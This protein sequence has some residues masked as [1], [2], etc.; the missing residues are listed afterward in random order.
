[1]NR[2]GAIQTDLPPDVARQRS[3]TGQPPRRYTGPALKIGDIK[4]RA[5]IAM[6]LTLSA[7]T[8]VDPLIRDRRVLERARG[9]GKGRVSR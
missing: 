7:S 5:T 2:S 6:G 3:P 1:M 8:S 4:S 9:A